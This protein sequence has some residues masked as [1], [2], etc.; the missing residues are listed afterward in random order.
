MGRLSHHVKM[1]S[2]LL[3][4]IFLCV[5]GAQCRPQ[6]GKTPLD[7]DTKDQT[8]IVNHIK[9]LINNVVANDQDHVK[10]GDLPKP[11]EFS[12]TVI[13]T[14][15]TTTTRTTT[16]R[17]TTTTR[18]PTEAVT[19]APGILSR[20]VNG[21]GSLFSGGILN[22]AGNPLFGAIPIGRKKRGV[23]DE[24]ELE[25][26]RQK[27]IRTGRDRQE[28][29]KLRQVIDQAFEHVVKKARRQ[30]NINEQSSSDMQSI[31]EEI[32]LEIAQ[33]LEQLNENEIQSY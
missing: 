28:T 33:R 7:K 14:G 10:V 32:F 11:L 15:A 2:K 18:R 21:I 3:G 17:T 31:K 30:S 19:E 9:E 5:I 25:F 23:I 4:I 29:A 27:L 13:K 12:N 26:L 1:D 22:A 24:S 8:K 20:I 16:R 6:N